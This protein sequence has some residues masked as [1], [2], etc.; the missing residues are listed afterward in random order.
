MRCRL[1]SYCRQG[2]RTASYAFQ[3]RR[4]SAHI[5]LGQRPGSSNRTHNK[6]L[7]ARFSIEMSRAFSARPFWPHESLGRCPRLAMILRRWR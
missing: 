6:A 2:R 5:S 4:R 7:K 1:R 3:R